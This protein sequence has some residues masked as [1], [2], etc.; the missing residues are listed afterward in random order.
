MQGNEISSMTRIAFEMLCHSDITGA[1]FIARQQDGRALHLSLAC[2]ALSMRQRSRKL[3]ATPSVPGR[4]SYNKH[5][6]ETI[7]ERVRI[8]G[9]AYG[10]IDGIG[11]AQIDAFSSFQYESVTYRLLDFDQHDCAGTASLAAGSSPVSLRHARGCKSWQTKTETI[12]WAADSRADSPAKSP[13]SRISR[14]SSAASR[15]AG[16][17][18][19]ATIRIVAPSSA[20]C[21]LVTKE[22]RH[23][24]GGPFL[25]YFLPT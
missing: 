17:R 20:N 14:T 12:R 22:G 5:R 24:H 2:R 11:R 10:R 6:S 19:A 3:P 9:H 16:S 1:S 4:Y 15:V 21:N 25:L 8:A 23:F 13:I 18:N 7:P